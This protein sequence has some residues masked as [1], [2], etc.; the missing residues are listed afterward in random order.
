MFIV[1][2]GHCDL[3]LTGSRG[4]QKFQWPLPGSLLHNAAT[5][6]VAATGTHKGGLLTGLK[7]PPQGGEGGAT[8]KR[9]SLR[10]GGEQCWGVGT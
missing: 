4:T 9:G 10:Q 6:R 3:V 5:R 8:K 7:A 1:G 2:Q